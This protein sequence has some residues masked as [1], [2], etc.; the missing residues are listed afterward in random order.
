[1]QKRTENSEAI[2]RKYPEQVVIA[3]A[4]ELKID[5]VI[6][7]E[8]KGRKYARRHH[9]DTIGTLGILI[10][11]KNKQLIKNIAPL[12]KKMENNGIRI[13]DKLKQ[14]ILNIAKEF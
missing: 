2:K 9:L 5:T 13:G 11:A 1:M 12:L 8:L 10:L 6:I 14:K 3:I 4:K 7:D